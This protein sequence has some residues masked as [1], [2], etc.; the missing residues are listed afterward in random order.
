VSVRTDL[1]RR[2]A[3]QN[4]RRLAVFVSQ[5]ASTPHPATGLLLTDTSIDCVLHRLSLVVRPWPDVAAVWRRIY[6][7]GT[8]LLWRPPARVTGC[9]K[10]D[11]VLGGG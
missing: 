5:H 6:N 8:I 9:S 3:G 11:I 10:H 4:E 7:D 2:Q 1:A